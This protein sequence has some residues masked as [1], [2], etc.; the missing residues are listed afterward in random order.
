MDTSTRIELRNEL[1]ARMKRAIAP[2]VADT[3][4]VSSIDSTGGI[5]AVAI[6]SS[7]AGAFIV[8]HSTVTADGLVIGHAMDKVEIDTPE[9][10]IILDTIK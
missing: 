10:D 5:V 2:V 1:V 9:A 3:I 8:C 4:L 6:K 7:N